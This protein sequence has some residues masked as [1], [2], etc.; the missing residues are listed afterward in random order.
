MARPEN[1]IAY[2]KPDAAAL[3]AAYGYG[4]SRNHAFIDGNKRTGFVAVE[5]F[6]S[7]NGYEL[8]AADTDCVLTM[9]RVSS[10]ELE[11]EQFAEWIR[12]HAAKR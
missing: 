2:G 8:Q 1:L 12:S 5:L 9:L 6:L 4:I 10:G 11:E 3:A 7:L